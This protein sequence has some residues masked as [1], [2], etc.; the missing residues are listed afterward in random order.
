LG[1]PFIQP[2]RP[3]L[4]RATQEVMGQFVINDVGEIASGAGGQNDEIAILTPFVISRNLDLLAVVLGRQVSK[5][6]II[7]DEKN[8]DRQIRKLNSLES[9]RRTDQFAKAFQFAQD[10]PGPRLADR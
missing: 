8:L 3:G 2:G 6:R 7:T 10:A 9:N 1:K 4:Q 5:L